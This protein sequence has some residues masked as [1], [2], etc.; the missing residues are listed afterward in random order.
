RWTSPWPERAVTKSKCKMKTLGKSPSISRYFAFFILNFALAA[1]IAGCAT[2]RA[3]PPL[4]AATVEQLIELLREREAAIRTLKGLFRAQIKA[5]GI[6][7]AQQ[8]EGAV[9]YRRPDAFRLQGFNRLGRE[10]LALV[11]GEDRYRVRLR[12]WGQ[13]CTGRVTERD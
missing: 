4:R 7:I 3:Q 10:L 2:W 5:P 13:V 8:V 12:T 1:A 6:P 9:L 11:L